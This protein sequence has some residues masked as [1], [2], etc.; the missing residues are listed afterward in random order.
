MTK[1]PEPENLQM[2]RH[3]FSRT[4]EMGVAY[5]TFLNREVLIGSDKTCL[6][7]FVLVQTTH[8]LLI[9]YYSFIFSL[10]DPSAV[11]F[12]IITESISAELPPDMHEI[13][14]LILEQWEKIKKPMAI[15]RHKI[16]FHH[17]Q[18]QTDVDFG[19][20]NYSKIHPLSPELIMMALRVFFRRLDDIYSSNEPYAIKPVEKDTLVLMDQVRKMKEY[21]EKNPHQDIFENL[22][23]SLDG[24]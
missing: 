24:F 7:D 8:T 5:N 13:R 11:N 14:N 9:T 17:S 18:S 10:F 15:I 20:T 19:Y 22:R 12:K 16:G 23:E 21:I 6:N 3:R 1:L 2:L 4:I